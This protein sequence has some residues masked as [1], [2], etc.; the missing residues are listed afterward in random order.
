MS[1]VLRDY[2]LDHL[3][4]YMRWVGTETPICMNLSEPGTGKTPSVVIN[5]YRRAMEGIQTLWVMPKSLIMKNVDEIMRFSPLER[6][7]IGVL[8]GTPANIEAEFDG[9]TKAV[10]LVNGTR[11]DKMER[12]GAFDTL[13]ALDVDEIHMLFKGADSM[14]T[15]SFHSMAFRVNEGVLMTGSLMDGGIAPAWPSIH[16]VDPRYYPGGY[17]AFKAHHSYQSRYDNKT[18]WINHEKVSTILERHSVRKVFDNRDQFLLPVTW[19]DPN[20][21]QKQALKDWEEKASI[22]IEKMFVTNAQPGVAYHAMRAILDHPNEINIEGE[23]VSLCKV[24]DTQKYHRLEATLYEHLSMDL[25][26]II[27]SALR[28]QQRW[29]AAL[30]EKV[31]ISYMLMD[32]NTSLDKRAKIDESFREGSHLVTIASYK[33]A[34]VGFNWQILGGKELPRVINMSLPY[35]PDDIVQGF[36][37][38]IRGPRNRTL[39]VE[40]YVSN[41]KFERRLM[42]RLKEKSQQSNMT[43]A[44]YPILEMIL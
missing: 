18:H 17:N 2:Q 42:S 1:M 43:D 32:G 30:C 4:F 25:P 15:K 7:H 21:E 36:R 44:S 12:E 5:Q 13:G 11:F 16:A 14:R 9:G 3:A 28:P 31:G 22:E 26:L 34:A 23:T 27:Y 35:L 29:I 40:S 39:L 24:E 10:Y 33:V 41:T 37:R 38:G 20:S 6:K 8:D 19:T